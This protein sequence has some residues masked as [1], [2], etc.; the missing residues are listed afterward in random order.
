MA[1]PYAD[2]LL[3]ELLVIYIIQE[4]LTAK[5]ASA[6]CSCLAAVVVVA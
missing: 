3:A 6:E 4:V 2:A 5:G 1:Q